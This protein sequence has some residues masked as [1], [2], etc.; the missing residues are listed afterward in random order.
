LAAGW[1]GAFGF[2]TLALPVSFNRGSATNAVRTDAANPA[3]IASRQLILSR[4]A[5]PF[6]HSEARE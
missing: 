5:L 1:F 2:K 6:L 3:R 4:T